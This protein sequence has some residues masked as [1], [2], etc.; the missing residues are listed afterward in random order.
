LYNYINSYPFDVLDGY[1]GI[2][3]RVN[4]ESENKDTLLM[5]DYLY[6][7][8]DSTYI[9][10]YHLENGSCLIYDKKTKKIIPTIKMEEWRDSPAPLAGAGGRRFYIKNELFLETIDWIS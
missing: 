7:I 4:L 10:A 9:L 3:E 5:T 1:D 8:K 2:K 6:Y